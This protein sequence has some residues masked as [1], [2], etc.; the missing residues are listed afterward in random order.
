[1]RWLELLQDAGAKATVEAERA[2]PAPKVNEI[3]I[4]I[5]GAEGNDPGEIAIGYYIEVGRTV[6]LT[7]EKGAPLGE[8]VAV[9]PGIN[10]AAIARSLMSARW[11]E[12]SFG[13]RLN[14]PPLAI[15]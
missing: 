6:I 2:K 5:R 12:T 1:M 15:A 3:V 14:Y 4:S 11:S 7:D 10:P 8:A 13:R 9:G